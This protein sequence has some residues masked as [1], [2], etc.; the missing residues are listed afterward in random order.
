MKLRGGSAGAFRILEDVET[1]VLT[2]FHE[3]HSLLEVFV[4]LAW[5]TDDDVARQCQAAARVPD[6]LNSLEI[7]ATFVT[8]AHQ[9]Q[10]AIA[11][12]LHR[13]VNPIAE[14]RILFDCRNDVR[15]EITRERGGELDA[16]QTSRSHCAQETA[17]RRRACESFETVFNAWPVAIDVLADKMNFL[18]AKRLQSLCFGDDLA[19]R[20]A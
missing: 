20:A 18:V 14:G 12:R 2:L 3:G 5:K 6:P 17:E 11:A 8:T 4:R 7:V 15:M 19:G 10:N 1:V 16:R 13:K 9:L